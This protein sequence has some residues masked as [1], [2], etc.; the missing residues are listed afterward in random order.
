MSQC[1]LSALESKFEAMWIDLFPHIDLVRQYRF[2]PVRRWRFDYASPDHRVAIEIQGGIWTNG[3]HSRGS[4][5]VQEFEKMNAAAHLGWRVF[6]LHAGTI[7]DTPTLSMIA[8]TIA[9]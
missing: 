7:N 8:N 2:H 9:S 5:Q 3:R 1:K 4:G 6:F